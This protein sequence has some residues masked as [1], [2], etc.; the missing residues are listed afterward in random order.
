[1]RKLKGNTRAKNS[2][3]IKS[4][5][6][7]KDFREDYEV[8][9]PYIHR[10]IVGFI[11]LVIESEDEISIFK[12]VDE[13]KK[14]EDSVKGL[15]LESA[16]YPKT[17]DASSKNI[18][19][20]LVISDNRKNRKT[21]LSKYSILGNQPFEILFLNEE[22]GYVE[23]ISELKDMLPR[24]FQTQEMKLDDGALKRL[25]SKPNHSKIER[26]ILNVEGSPK[27]ITEELIEKMDRYVKRNDKLPEE[28]TSI[29]NPTEGKK[30]SYQGRA[31]KS[32]VERKN[33]VKEISD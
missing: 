27:R 6:E 24:L 10:G 17:R 5:I 31:E 13:A 26:A 29:E 7:L 33:G 2:G 30:E 14:I 12:F 28:F 16:I 23:S 18:E 15:K 9:V 20:Y 1:M 22:E 19:S 3:L 32:S 25:I 8:W 4:F 11:D 21:V